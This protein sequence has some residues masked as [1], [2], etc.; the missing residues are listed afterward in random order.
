MKTPREKYL[1]DNHYKIL[2]DTMMFYIERCHYTPSE[3][4][5]AAI[6]ASILYEEQHVGKHLLLNPEIEEALK[7][8][9]KWTRTPS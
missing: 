7:K 8:L 1:N 4:R 9:H 2:V 6:L 5:E 3:L